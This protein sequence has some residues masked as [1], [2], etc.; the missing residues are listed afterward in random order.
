[1]CARNHMLD[2]RPRIIHTKELRRLCQQPLLIIIT[3]KLKQV[4]IPSMG[5]RKKDLHRNVCQQCQCGS[6]SLWSMMIFFFF[7]IEFYG[8]GIFRFLLWDFHVRGVDFF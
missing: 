7:L 1:M 4:I 3:Y 5:T 8:E 2:M 6:F